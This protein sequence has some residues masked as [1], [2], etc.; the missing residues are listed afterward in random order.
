MAVCLFHERRGEGMIKVS[1]YYPYTE[2]VKFDFNYYTNSHIPLCKSRLGCSKVE[3]SK[4]ISDTNPNDPPMYVATADMYFD[5]VEEVHEG[6][7]AHGREL[8]TDMPNYT[9]I[10]PLFIIAEV[11]D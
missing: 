6:F 5:N 4:G 9:D 11:L 1:A 2:G 7:K 3:V 10:K 8:F